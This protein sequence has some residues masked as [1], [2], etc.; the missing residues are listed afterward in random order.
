MKNCIGMFLIN[1]N[2]NIA[3]MYCT[4]K[5]N[6]YAHHPHKDQ[7]SSESRLTIKDKNIIATHERQRV[8]THCESMIPEFLL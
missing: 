8:S 2:N 4:V 1:I 6:N 3:S 7:T 5:Q